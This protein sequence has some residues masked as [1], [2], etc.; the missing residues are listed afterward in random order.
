MADYTNATAMSVKGA[1]VHV[2]DVLCAVDGAVGGAVD[3]AVGVN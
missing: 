1:C 2:L 3:G